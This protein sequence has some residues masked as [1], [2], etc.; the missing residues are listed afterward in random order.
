[1]EEKDEPRG[2]RKGTRG[3]GEGG[4]EMRVRDRGGE[5]SKPAI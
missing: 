2:M 5:G 4:G 1:M 3:R